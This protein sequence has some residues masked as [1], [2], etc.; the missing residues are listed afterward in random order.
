MAISGYSMMAR[1]SP[2]D[3]IE[4]RL[5]HLASTRTAAVLAGLEAAAGGDASAW[6]EQLAR[7]AGVLTGEGPDGRRMPLI[8]A[9]GMDRG[10][11]GRARAERALQR[12]RAQG[13]EVTGNSK[14]GIA[15]PHNPGAAEIKAIERAL[16]YAYD[17]E[18]VVTYANG[19]ERQ[20]GERLATRAMAGVCG[21]MMLRNLGRKSERLAPL[22]RT[23]DGVHPL[24]GQRRDSRASG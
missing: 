13:P 9:L 12:L 24:T 2:A 6:T 17:E 3:K 4:M 19:H 11:E 20:R 10:P 22:G 16:D 5:G 8:E 7:Y 15:V 21:V 18:C 23:E 1:M 14:I